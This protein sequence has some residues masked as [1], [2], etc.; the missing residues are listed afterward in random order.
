MKP[1]LKSVGF[2]YVK[3][4]PFPQVQYWEYEQA[5]GR[6]SYAGNPYAEFP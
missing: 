6:F 2:L 5:C 1:I 3:K 4:G